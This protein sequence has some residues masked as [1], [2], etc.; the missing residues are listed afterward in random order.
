MSDR[1]NNHLT[2][3][4]SSQLSSSIHLLLITDVDFYFSGQGKLETVASLMVEGDDSMGG[5]TFNYLFEVTPPP[6]T[7]L[8][9]CV[10]RHLVSDERLVDTQD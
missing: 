8:V 7:F 6:P 2:N 1:I 3:L 4:V 5:C 9:L 10:N